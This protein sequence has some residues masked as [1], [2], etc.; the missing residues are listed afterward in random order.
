MP[1]LWIWWTVLEVVNRLRKVRGIWSGLALYASRMTSR[2]TPCGKLVFV[3]CGVL[4]ERTEELNLHRKNSSVFL[5]LRSDIF[6][7]LHSSKRVQYFPPVWH[8]LFLIH[9]EEV[10][11]HHES[12]IFL[13]T[14]PNGC[15][16]SVMKCRPYIQQCVC[17]HTDT[18]QGDFSLCSLSTLS[19][20]FNR[21]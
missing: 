19:F 3:E 12:A 8:L 10:T 7:I 20:K 4:V 15:G 13:P 6:I 11:I 17:M 16:C 1:F 21:I 2:H 14:L 5:H 9:Q 18:P